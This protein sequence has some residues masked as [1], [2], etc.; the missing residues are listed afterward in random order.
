MLLYDITCF[1][2][3]PYSSEVFCESVENLHV[4]T[5]SDSRNRPIVMLVLP[6]S[7]AI[8]MVS[9]WSPLFFAGHVIF[10]SSPI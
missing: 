7:I 3:K 2:N 6:M 1:S 5:S 10:V 4:E 8:S 9:A